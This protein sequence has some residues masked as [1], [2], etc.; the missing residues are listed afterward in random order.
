MQRYFTMILPIYQNKTTTKKTNPL[1]SALLINLSK[2]SKQN[3]TKNINFRK[4]LKTTKNVR[5]REKIYEVFSSF[6]YNTSSLQCKDSCSKISLM[7]LQIYYV[8]DSTRSNQ[9]MNMRER[10]REKDNFQQS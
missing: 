10:E 5:R 9:Y 2:S 1:R 7:S 4:S 8:F 6:S 3:K